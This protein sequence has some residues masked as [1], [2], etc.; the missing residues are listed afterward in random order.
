VCVPADNDD[1]RAPLLAA[2]GLTAA[3]W[4]AA[5]AER[6]PPALGLAVNLPRGAP[7]AAQNAAV[8]QARESGVTMFGLTVSWSQAEPSPRHF[9]VENVTRAARVLR[10]SGALLHLD[11]PIVTAA[12]RDVPADLAEIPFDDPRL[13]IRLGRLLQ[14]LEP[15]LLDFATI[16]LGN[17]A[18][19]YFSEK[20]GELRGFR[21]LVEG[22]V[23][24]L[25]KRVPGLRV[26]VTTLAPTE[27]RAPEIAA[28]L[29]ASSP[30]LFY[31]YAPIVPGSPFQHRPPADLERDWKRLLESSRGRPIAFPEVS[32][33]SAPE[34]GSTPAKQA[35]FIRRFRRFIAAADGSR[36]LFARYVPWRDPAPADLPPTAGSSE[37]ARRRT[38]FFAN[39]G[40]QTTDA[41][42]KPA[43]QEWLRAERTERPPPRLKIAR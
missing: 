17:E 8:E 12:A 39:R 27:S 41:R 40:L 37:G 3:V 9:Q 36:L 31:I 30:V 25:G 11:L 18:D 14:A 35:E 24:F 1:V 38:T 20:P 26:G 29:H 34:N 28:T 43:W 4:M 13:T 2:L 16:S 42:P 22:A 32:Y 21:R 6:R 7:P 23:Q 33:S 19:S 15:A 10:Q 5:E